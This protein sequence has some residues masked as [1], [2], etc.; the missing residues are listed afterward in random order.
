MCENSKI[1]Q[2]YQNILLMIVWKIFKGLF[3]ATP[4]STSHMDSISGRYRPF[5]VFTDNH[6]QKWWEFGFFSPFLKIQFS[7]KSSIKPFWKISRIPNF[8]NQRISLSPEFVQNFKS[9]NKEE[10]LIFRL[11]TWNIAKNWLFVETARHRP[12]IQKDSSLRLKTKDLK[13]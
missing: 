6:Q 5:S 3:L 10:V 7:E 2:N 12:L 13:S 1:S 4:R 11:K 9:K 8:Y